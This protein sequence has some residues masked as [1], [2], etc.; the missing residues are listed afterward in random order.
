MRAIIRTVPRV[1]R[2]TCHQ[3]SSPL[4]SCVESSKH[5]RE[6]WLILKSQK[7]LKSRGIEKMLDDAREDSRDTD[8]EYLK[9]GRE[10]FF[11]QLVSLLSL[12]VANPSFKHNN[13][14][15]YIEKH[16]WRITGALGPAF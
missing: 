8:Q 6:P 10:Y 4:F 1:L 11:S 13:C 15:L 3:N 9:K 12:Y 14:P 5:K 16:R 7:A 2:S